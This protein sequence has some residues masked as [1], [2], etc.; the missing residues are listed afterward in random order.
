MM[1]ED[2]IKTIQRKVAVSAVGPSALRGQGKGV[3]WTSQDFLAHMSLE[4]VPKSNAKKFQLW[5]DP[6]TELLLD[7]K[8]AFTNI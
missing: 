3:L 5:L 8:F 2:F 4:R 6:Q 7:V 1:P